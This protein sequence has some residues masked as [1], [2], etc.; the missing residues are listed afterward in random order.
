MDRK[1]EINLKNS[2]LEDFQNQVSQVLVRHKSVLDVM[3]KL[4]EYNARINRAIAKSVT[5]CGCI[6]VSANKQEFGNVSLE[7]MY[8]KAKTHIGGQVCE[9]CT[10]VIEEEMGGYLFYLASLGNTLGIDLDSVMN[11]E[12]NRIKTLGIYSLK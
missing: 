3:T 7:D 1:N 11:K 2:I 6:T 5:S 4:D 8:S 9:S 10:D 12:Y